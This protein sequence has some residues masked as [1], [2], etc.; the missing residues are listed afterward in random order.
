MSSERRILLAVFSIAFGVR[1]LYAALAGMDPSINPDP[2]TP[3]AVYGFEIASGISWITTP[4]SPEAPAYPFMLGMVFLLAGKHIWAAIILQALLGGVLAVI[5]LKLGQRVAGFGAGLFAAMWLALYVHHIYFSGILVRDAFSCLILTALVYRL[6][7]PFKKMRYSLLAGFL[8]AVLV[9]TDPQYMLLLPVFILFILLSKTRHLVINIQFL[10]LF[11]SAIFV[12]SIPWTV[13]NYYV[14]KQFI[15]V[16]L[17]SERY[18][19][20]VKTRIPQKIKEMTASQGTPVS[21]SRLNRI[22]ENAVEFWRITSFHPR[23]PGGRQ[24]SSSAK[25]PPWSLRHNLISIVSFG[26]LLPFFIIG[27]IRALMKKQ[28]E[29]LLLV[30]VTLFYFLIRIFYGGSERIRLQ[31]EPLIIILAFYALFYMTAAGHRKSSVGQPED[32]EI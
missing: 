30:F 21:R 8:Y 15:P 31:I 23:K 22:R 1:I 20:P 27:T 10:M 14:Y 16:G 3:A 5:A 28:R 6:A 24:G 29:A 4:F 18:I 11:L 12:I 26:I 25:L 32:Y 7:L 2:V 13:R 9:H 17:E 19:S